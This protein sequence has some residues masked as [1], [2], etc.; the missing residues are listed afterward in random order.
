MAYLLDDE[1]VIER[2]FKPLEKIPNSYPKY[3][4]S[5][6]KFWGNDFNGIKRLNILD[7]LFTTDFQC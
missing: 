3:V 6:D 2:E 5:M 4:L 7:F 1:K